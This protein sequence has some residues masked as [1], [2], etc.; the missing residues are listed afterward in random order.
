MKY[1]ML[2]IIFTITIPLSTRASEGGLATVGNG[3]VRYL[4]LF[5]VYEAQL[6]APID[7]PRNKILDR[8]TPRCLLL[9]YAVSLDAEDLAKG[10]DVVLARQQSEER[11]DK[12]REYID[13]LHKSYEDVQSG[14]SYSLCY[15]PA[16]TTT[17]LSLNSAEVV[18]IDSEEFAEI[19][20]GIWLGE[21]EPIDSGLRDSLLKNLPEQ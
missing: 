13:I 6:L 11:L 19:Y 15:S 14:D 5:K 3:E 12:L 2:L 10:G 17:V 18:S 21:R 4:G 8:T 20:F 1:F 16:S 7:T 9:D